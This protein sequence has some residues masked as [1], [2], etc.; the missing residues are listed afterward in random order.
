MKVYDVVLNEGK[1]RGVFG[2]S[3]V[4]NPAMEGMFIALSDQKPQEVK[5]A[6]VD[7]EKRILMGVA[8]I[9]D[10]KIYRN[11]DGEEFF[12]QFSKD[13]I[14]KAAHMF[15]SN[16]YQNESSLEHQLKL[17]GMSIVE[18]WIIEDKDN[19]KSRK[20]GFDYPEG[21]WMV[22]M[23]VNDPKIW[24]EFVKKGVIKGFSIDGLFSLKEVQLNKNDMSKSMVE[25]IKEGFA[26]LSLNKDKPAEEL[27][28]ET[29]EVKLGT[30]KLADGTSIEFDGETIEAG[31]SIFLQ[32]EEDKVPLPV[33]EY[34]LE[35]GTTVTVTEEGTVGSVGEAE[36]KED[37]PVEAAEPDVVAQ[38]KE[39]VAQLGADLKKDFDTQLA[40]IK[41]AKEKEITD[42][43]TELSKTEGAAPT[44]HA[45]KE[46]VE[47]PSIT[48]KGRLTQFLNNL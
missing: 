7:T 12:I 4:E 38:I 24:D 46:V 33:G 1:E 3:V 39:L 31:A 30:A 41:E 21:S 34:V 48:K 45:P 2:I 44:K 32:G 36:A 22:S 14:E 35:D 19:D 8:L 18:S 11:I 10:K 23:K 20:H 9:P 15:L 40:E 6:K 13:T 43:K 29:V 37:V 25:A 26:G 17:E 5:L 42:L 28:P 27:K 47:I 16:G